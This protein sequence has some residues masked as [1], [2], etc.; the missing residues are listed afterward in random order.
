MD[1]ERRPPAADRRPAP[2]S[3]NPWVELP[4]SVVAE[5]GQRHID[6]GKAAQCR[7]CPVAL[8]VRDALARFATGVSVSVDTVGVAEI[9]GTS[10][11][12]PPKA[13]Y[14][15]AGADAH[16]PVRLIARFDEG[17]AVEPVAIRYE[18]TH[19]DGVTF[20]LRQSHY[21]WA[22]GYTRAMNG[23][24]WMPGCG[25]HGQEEREL[26]QRRVEGFAAWLSE[27]GVRDADL[28][29]DGRHAYDTDGG[30]VYELTAEDLADIET[31]L[32]FYA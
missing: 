23:G 8:A 13:V 26:N 12:D 11:S 24:G 22:G 7:E 9:T 6:R 16:V 25:P 4:L 18:R 31:A 5:V 14:V 10:V 21:E 19:D 32:R 29:L 27:N 3:T 17:E 15:P 20:L 2:V 1:P 28:L 30:Q